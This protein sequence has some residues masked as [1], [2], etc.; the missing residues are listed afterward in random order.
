MPATD[1]GLLEM[2]AR[3]A[4]EIAR[5][6]WRADPKVWDKG[7][8][9][10]VSEADLAVDRHLRERLMAARPDYGW[11]SEETEDDP[12]ARKSARRVFIVDPI[13]G[14]RS[15]VAGEKTWAHSLAVVEGGRVR[16]ACVFLPVREKLYLAAKGA[17]ASLNGAR[18]TVS[19][20]EQVDGA[21]VLSPKVSFR[22]EYWQDG[23]PPVKRHFRPSLAYRMALIG[24]GRFDAMLTLRPA[25][26]WD[27]A[28]GALIAEEAGATVTD[29]NGRVLR[30]NSRERQTAGVVA[31]NT[32]LHGALSKRLVTA[33][34]AG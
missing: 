3:E 14:T 34:K 2:V 4:G 5:K 19:G 11:L 33:E 18:L 6:Y 32:E 9:D 20:R 31:A 8:N 24:E 13:D 29:R 21:T 26:E 17:G 27:I 28:A 12:A 16:A 30:F 23:V 25:W 10:P 1:L 15:F 22:E 7:S